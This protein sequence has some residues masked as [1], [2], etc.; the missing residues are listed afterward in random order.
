[1]YEDEFLEKEEYLEMLKDFIKK[2]GTTYNENDY[3]FDHFHALIVHSFNLLHLYKDIVEEN[4]ELRQKIN[5]LYEE[6]DAAKSRCL[7]LEKKL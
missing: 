7:F 5:L 1:M 6:L 4:K 3:E 2:D